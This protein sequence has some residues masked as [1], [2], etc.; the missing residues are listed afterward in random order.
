M[1]KPLFKERDGHFVDIKSNQE[2]KQQPIVSSTS[3][4]IQPPVFFGKINKEAV[5]VEEKKVE[6]KKKEEFVK[7]EDSKE[8]LAIPVFVNTK[9]IEGSNISLEKDV[10]FIFYYDSYILKNSL[11]QLQSQRIYIKAKSMTSLETNRIVKLKESI[12][13]KGIQ[14]IMANIKIIQIRSNN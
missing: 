7:K 11:T 13:I 9:K 3:N 14:R 4:S 12:Q 1:Q 8:D 5:I 2:V 6:E 10:S